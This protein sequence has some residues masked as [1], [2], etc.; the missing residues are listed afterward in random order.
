MNETNGWKLLNNTSNILTVH[1]NQNEDFKKK[2]Y[3]QVQ[4]FV[5]IIVSWRFFLFF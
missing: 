2:Y 5:L 1:K 3:V 4:S